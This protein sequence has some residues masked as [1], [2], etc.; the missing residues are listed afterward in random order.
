MVKE[1]SVLTKR[2]GTETR[3]IFLSSPPFP[4]RNYVLYESVEVVSSSSG[5]FSY[6][7]GPVNVFITQNLQK[8][9]K[10]SSI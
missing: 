9:N 3:P 5:S 10:K 7:K 4:Y 2:C 1:L 6:F 8:F